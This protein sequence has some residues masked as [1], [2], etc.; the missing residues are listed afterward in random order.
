MVF[1]IPQEDSPHPLARHNIKKLCRP[2]PDGSGQ[3]GVILFTWAKR[4]AFGSDTGYAPLDERLFEVLDMADSFKDRQHF[5]NTIEA[6]ELRREQAT[7]TRVRDIAYG[8][9]EY[10]A[11]LDSLTI[12]MNPSTHAPG[13]WRHRIR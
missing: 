12:S 10:W 3:E 6:S 4:D 13:D 8:A 1:A 5:E 7:N 2:F 11:N 9:K